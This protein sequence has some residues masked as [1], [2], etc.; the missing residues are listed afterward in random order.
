M[1]EFPLIFHAGIILKSSP[2][3]ESFSNQKG[4]VIP[5]MDKKMNSEGQKTILI[6]ED[7][8]ILALEEART[9]EQYGYKVI[10][11]SSGEKAIKIVETTS[12]IDL[13]LMDIKLGSGMDG[14]EAAEKILE[15]HNL[16]I[17]FL[18]SY[19]ERKVVEKTEGIPSYGYI[20][21]N[22]GEPVL[23]ASIRMAFRLFEA[24]MKKMAKDET[25]R[26][27][28]FYLKEAQAIAQMGHW[29]LDPQT[30]KVEGS[31]ELFRIFHLNREHDFTLE[32]FYDVV[33][34][35]DI[36]LNLHH[37]RR[38]MEH[39]EPWDIEYRIICRDSTEKWIRAKGEAITD[40]SGD[41]IELI[42]T[43]QDIT[44]RKLAEDDLRLKDYIIESAS[45]IIAT[46][47]LEGNMT[48]VN[49]SFLQLWGFKNEQEVIGRH[50]KEFWMAEE[51]LDEL[52]DILK[53]EGK[54]HGE[55]RA[56]KKD[57]TI[58]DVQVSAA[59]VYDNSGKPI[60]FMSSSVDIT[61]RKRADIA[62]QESLEFKD[63]VI[64]ESPVGISIY[65]AE[66]GQ[67][68]AANEAIGKAVGASVEQV[69]G[70]NFYNIQS[71]KESGLLETAKNALRTNS[72][73]M[74]ELNVTTTFGK[75]VSIDCHFAP[76]FTGGKKYL[77]FTTTD[78]S[79]RKEA[80]NKLKES[81]IKFST[82]F[83]SAPILISITKLK[84]GEFIDANET[85]LSVTGYGRE[86]VIGHTSTELNLFTPDDRDRLKQLLKKQ[87]IFRNEEFDIQ[88]KTGTIIN[89][90]FSAQ[91]IDLAGEQCIVS[92]AEDITARKRTEE[93]LRKEK[94][95]SEEYIN[96]LPGL[97]YV[98]DDERFVKWNKQWEIVTGYS[99]DE[100]GKMYGPDFVH[101]SDKTLVSERMKEVFSKGASEVQAS[102]ITKKG[103]QIPYY[104][105]G[106]RKEFNGK[107]HLVGLG[108][109]IT[110]L[111][112]VEEALHESKQLLSESQESANIGSWVWDLKSEIV[113]WSEQFYNISGRDP[114]LG[115][116]PM[117]F[118]LETCHPDDRE[119]LRNALEET[120]NKD[121]SFSIDY[122]FFR[123]DNGEERWMRSQGKLEKD[124]KGKPNRLIGIAQDITERKQVEKKIENLLQ[125]KEILLKEVHHRIKNNMNVIRSLLSLQSNALDNPEAVT[126]LQ[127]AIGRIESMGVLYDKLYTT[128][129]YQD[130]SIKEYL[131]QLINEIFQMF[132]DRQNIKIKTKIN[133]FIIGTKVIF[134]LGI[135]VNELLTNAMKYAFTGRESGLIHLSAVL[136]RNH[137]TIIFEDNGIGMPELKNNERQKGFG[138]KLIGL[139]TKQ[140]NGSYKIE[141]NKGTK[142]IIEFDI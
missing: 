112:Q 20:V 104:F 114:D 99:A 115:V 127:D 133:D 1:T 132:P 59:T 34:P 95:L 17:I 100:L 23:M 142:F 118:Y 120:I 31:D 48:Y 50:F 96:S 29:R 12:D 108:V 103:E 11:A 27:N 85:F 70:Q 121:I 135:I 87:G 52:I 71:W 49:S 111:K 141:T 76:F 117:D 10:T 15:K 54:W 130:V 24:K 33:H 47:S 123:E 105:N 37:I 60:S 75:V 64:S 42:G 101:D 57:G 81:E 93:E 18:S 40:K 53:T 102:I 58:F 113:D 56:K 78:Y 36:E 21:K 90:S 131:P 98:F 2:K 129:S 89:T 16:P 68:V 77:L 82:T 46:A 110:K 74:L 122:R 134:P 106:L 136:K 137:V 9:L 67:C 128:E 38:G 83:N 25:L 107:P 97:F 140:I 28:E 80:E 8:A 86:E 92:V 39:G 69:L 72:K 51:I 62:L 35:D 88:I 41:V 119:P 61:E 79:Q 7:E 63:K 44:G 3:G 84:D 94:L 66:S 43:N 26:V 13:I 91:F 14:T 73:K 109:E 22:S 45:S 5:V 126:A 116:P 139:L 19:T 124:D 55:I 30:M 125:E 65:D 4:H 6:V 138:I 32:A